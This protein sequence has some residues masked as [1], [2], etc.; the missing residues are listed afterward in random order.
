VNKNKEIIVEFEDI[1]YRGLSVGR[2]QNKI[3]FAYGLLPGEKAKIKILKEKEDFVEG[4]AVELIFH[5]PFR[6]NKKEDHYLSCSPWQVFD[7]NY[8]AQLKEKILIDIF[9]K[10]TGKDFSSEIFYQFYKAEKIWQYR[11]KIEYSFVKE[12]NKLSFAFFKRGSCKEKVKLEKGCA[13]ISDRANDSAFAILNE[14]HQDQFNI[15]KS[16]IV[17]NSFLTEKAHISLLINT[18]NKFNLSIPPS[19]SGFVLAY[20][21]EKSPASRFDEVL[22]EEGNDYIKEKILGKEFKYHYTSFFQNNL[23]LFEKALLEMEHNISAVNKIVDLYCGVGVISICLSN[24]TKEIFGVDTESNSVQYALENAKHNGVRNFKGIVEK[25]EKITDG[26][27]NNCDVLIID[28]PRVGLHKKVLKNIYKNKPK[29]IFY[30]SCNPISQAQ[31]LLKLQDYYNV[32]KLY[33]FDFY[34]HTPH[35]ESLLILKLKP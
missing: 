18:K 10:F 22:L 24:Y 20:S 32:E 4:E 35:I 16:L 17:R 6:V 34:P 9:K 27:L 28:P 29:F 7:Y 1:N 23:E 14:L 33:G 30:L 5:S 13:L 12:N 15:L 3:V 25:A 21:D 26:I 8:Q 11:T 2:Y 31:D 19:L